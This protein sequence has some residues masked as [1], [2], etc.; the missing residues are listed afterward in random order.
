MESR[1]K[2]PKILVQLSV[3]RA[4]VEKKSKSQN[5]KTPSVFRI[6]SPLFFTTWMTRRQQ[7]TRFIL[8]SI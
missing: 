8:K 6:V 5:G 2:N 1:S 3:P 7:R 4:L